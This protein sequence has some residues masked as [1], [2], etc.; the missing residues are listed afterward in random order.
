MR[1]A[2][3]L[4]GSRFV[5]CSL[6]TLSWAT[7]LSAQPTTTDNQDAAFTSLE[8]PRAAYERPAHLFVVRISADVLGQQLNHQVDVTTPVRDVFL[9]TPVSGV[10]RLVGQPRVELVPSADQAR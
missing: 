10:A 7:W 3:L 4:W 9:G 6:L 2:F 8:P 1:A 5:G